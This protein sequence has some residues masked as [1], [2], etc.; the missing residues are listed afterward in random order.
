MVRVRWFGRRT[1]GPLEDD[2]M[3]VPGPPCILALDEVRLLKPPSAATGT[4]EWSGSPRSDLKL[5][6]VCPEILDIFRPRF[7]P[8]VTSKS[9][10]KLPWGVN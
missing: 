5:L 10:D 8:R 4:G 2:P 1:E 7:R 3:L 9:S 6:G